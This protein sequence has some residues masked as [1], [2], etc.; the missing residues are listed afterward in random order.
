MSHFLAKRELKKSQWNPNERQEYMYQY[1]VQEGQHGAVPAQD[2]APGEL[3]AVPAAHRCHTAPHGCGA[4]PGGDAVR[5]KHGLPEG[6]H[7]A[8][9]IDYHC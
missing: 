9:I 7:C 6:M 4:V 3:W 1:G 2:A 5:R 8:L